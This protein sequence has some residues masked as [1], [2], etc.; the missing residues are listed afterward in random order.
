M[1]RRQFIHQTL[2]ISLGLNAFNLSCAPTQ[3][4]QKTSGQ[5]FK[6]KKQKGRWMLINPKGEPFWSIGLNHVDA[7]RLR[8]LN[9]GEIW[10]EKYDN[11]ME[12]W[13]K[14]VQKDL[15]DW[16]FNTLGWNQEL[17]TF[18]AQNKHHS[19]SFTYEEYQW[20]DMP[21][22]HLL[23]FIES[24]QWETETRLP[25]IRS[26][27]FAEWCDYVAR[28]QCARMKD[29]PNLIGY[30][31]T[32]C[33]TWVHHRT[34]NAWKAP[35]FDP[36]QLKSSAGQKV[37]QTPRKYIH[38]SGD[39]FDEYY[40]MIRAVR[41]SR[42]KYLKNFKPNQGY[43]LP[44]AYRENMSTMQ[45]LLR[46]NKEGKLNDIQSQWFRTSKPAEE[47]FDTKN[48]PHE[49][50]NLA[51]NPNYQEKLIELRT[52]CEQWM[53]AIEDK[54]FIPEEDLIRQFWPDKQQPITAAP[55]IK[56]MDG[57][58]HISCKTEGAAI[59]Y[60]L[61]ADEQ[62]DIGWRVYQQPITL[63]ATTMKIVAHRIG[64]LPSDALVYPN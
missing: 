50:N 12:K 25:D 42:F 40:D 64:Y 61:P 29:D 15:T 16:G 3:N 7:A 43:Y 17:V 51:N 35:L 21:Y 38:A 44:L 63:P 22:C 52:E 23:P 36:D 11:S 9:S 46:M 4:H 49:L 30:F 59:G 8:Q 55:I 10:T 31:F 37:N 53:T 28:D 20:L 45:E 1:K 39:R 33:P 2:G 41:D 56:E 18:N 24:H 48:D 60:K 6:T 26:K 27:G 47:L 19:R 58:L 62:P 14:S 34:D 32:D 54:G 57:K 13:L 5:F